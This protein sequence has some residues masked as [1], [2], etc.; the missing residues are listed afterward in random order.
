MFKLDFLGSETYEKILLYISDLLSH[1]SDLT[2]C[3]YQ[4]EILLETIYCLNIKRKV[5]KQ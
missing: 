3:R 2:L 1:V 4:K 5:E